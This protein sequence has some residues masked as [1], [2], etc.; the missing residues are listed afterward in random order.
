MREGDQDV[1]RRAGCGKESRMWVG[2]HDVG[3]RAGCG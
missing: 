1:G 3:R 2:G